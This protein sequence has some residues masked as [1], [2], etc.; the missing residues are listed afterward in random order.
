MLYLLDGIPNLENICPYPD[1]DPL[2]KCNVWVDFLKLKTQYVFH[3][4][5]YGCHWLPQNAFI[6]SFRKSF[7]D[8]WPYWEAVMFVCFCVLLDLYL[9][10]PCERAQVGSQHINKSTQSLVELLRA[11]CME[12]LFGMTGILKHSKRHLIRHIPPCVGEDVGLHHCLFPSVVIFS[13]KQGEY[14][15]LCLFFLFHVT[16][17]AYFLHICLIHSQITIYACKQ[18]HISLLMVK[19]YKLAFHIE[20]QKAHQ[21]P[22][23]LNWPNL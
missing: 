16:Q 9:T 1:G 12:V 11:E 15:K 23:L 14:Y 8:F 13:T 19:S 4:E 3:Q 5:A 18:E 6:L 17:F 10:L 20:N 7:L 21:L 22:W 2:V